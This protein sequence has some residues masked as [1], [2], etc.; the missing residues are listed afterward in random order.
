MK[1]LTTHEIIAGQVHDIPVFEMQDCAGVEEIIKRLAAIEDILG[2]EYDLDR[3]RELV[4]AEKEDRY[5]IM[6]EPRRAGVHRLTELAE[7]DRDGRCK[8]L[9]CRDWLEIVFGD[10]DVFYGIDTDYLECPIR[11]ISVDSSSRCTWYDGWKTVVL[12]GYDENG[13]DW[14]FAPEDIGKTVFRTREA[15]EAALKGEQD[16]SKG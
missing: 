2:D 13:L 9:P 11:E 15:A 7:A 1:R 3:L 5:I 6:K 10:Q 16:G 14:E 12:K 8:V 4:E